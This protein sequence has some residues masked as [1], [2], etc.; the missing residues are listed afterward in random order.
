[1]AVKKTAEAKVDVEVMETNNEVAVEAPVEEVIV[2]ETPVVEIPEVK[3]EAKVE[4]KVNTVDETKKPEDNFKI[5]MRVDHRC[6][7]AGV[8][9][10]LKADKVYTVSA[11]A[12]RILNEAGLLA[13]L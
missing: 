13:P 6:T 9:Y 10:D 8:F 12:K 1:M 2:E 5:R 7:I 4:V 3:T 11:N